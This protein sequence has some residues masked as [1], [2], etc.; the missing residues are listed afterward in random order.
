MNKTAFIRRGPDRRVGFVVPRSNTV[1]EAEFN[2]MASPGLSFHAARMRYAAGARAPDMSRFMLDALIDPLADLALCDIDLMLLGCSTASMACDP[3]ALKGTV[4]QTLDRPFLD[5]WSVTLDALERVGVRQVALFTPYVE[6]GNRAVARV[7]DRRGLTVVADRGLGLNT[8]PE[9][10]RAASRLEP[11]DIADH[12]RS[13][14][15]AGADGLLLACCDM[16]T[17]D[18]IPR[19]EDTFGL[20]VISTIQA[21]Y[22]AA[23]QTL[24]MACSP[25]APG[26]LFAMS[27]SPARQ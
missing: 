24:G 14:D 26:R 20:P 10:F 18:A 17:F 15:L 19:L 3:E 27:A 9:R 2:R 12:V 5:V 16:P 13:M 6:D 22:W 8:S 11:D 1:C 21:L 25:A 23:M 4:Q 7:L